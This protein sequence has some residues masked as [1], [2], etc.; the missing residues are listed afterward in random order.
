MPG[1]VGCGGGQALLAEGTAPARAPCSKPLQS[2]PRTSG[3]LLLVAGQRLLRTEAGRAG[4]AGYRELVLEVGL[5]P[6]GQVQGGCP[7]EKKGIL[8]CFHL[9]KMP[10]LFLDLHQLVSDLQSIMTVSAFLRG[11]GWG[12]WAGRRQESLFSSFRSQNFILSQSPP[13]KAE[14]L[15]EDKPFRGQ[16]HFSAG[17]SQEGS[18]GRVA[19]IA[20]C[21]S[22]WPDDLCLS[23]GP[24][25]LKGTTS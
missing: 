13:R 8:P 18:H 23:F 9:P 24:L 6:E 7:P 15:V 17:D 25:T 4:R 10:W 21:I 3:G 5:R 19:Q 11:W 2:A 16:R 12:G 20:H 22:L 14:G 1:K